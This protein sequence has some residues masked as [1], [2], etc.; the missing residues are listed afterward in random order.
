MKG[1]AGPILHEVVSTESGRVSRFAH[2]EV[3]SRVM[4]VSK[5][6]MPEPNALL[7]EIGLVV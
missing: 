4:E 6:I 3:P 2:G 1:I 5:L 7:D